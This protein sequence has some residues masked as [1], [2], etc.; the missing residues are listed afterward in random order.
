M[1]GVALDAFDGDFVAEPDQ[2]RGS[3]FESSWKTVLLKRQKRSHGS[4]DLSKRRPAPSHGRRRDV[5]VDHVFCPP[6][7]I[8]EP[9]ENQMF[10]GRKFAA[11]LFDMD[12]TVHQFDRLGRAGLGE[13]ARRHGLDVAAFLPTIHG[14]R[15]IETIGRLALPGVDPAHEADCAAE[16]RGGRSG[17][18][19]ADCRRRGVSQARC[20]PSAG[21]SS[22]RRRARWR[23]CACRRPASR[24]PPDRRRRRTFPTASRRPIV[25]GSAAKRLGVDARDCLV[26]EDA[27]AGIAA[28]EAAGASVMVISAT[29][30][31]PQCDDASTP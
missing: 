14:V 12:G 20:R 17:W 24:F 9:L 21:R 15:A 10:A 16:G 6:E 27:P 13:W 18:H 23:C 1:T 11:F 2:H 22:P 7:T 28:A 29:H 19:S 8:P 25:S 30:Q 3:P 4:L 31:H 26:F 5:T